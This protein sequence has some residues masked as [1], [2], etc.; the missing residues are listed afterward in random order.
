[1]P[2]HL[3]HDTRNRKVEIVSLLSHEEGEAMVHTCHRKYK[4]GLG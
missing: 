1:M 2:E 3:R 4:W